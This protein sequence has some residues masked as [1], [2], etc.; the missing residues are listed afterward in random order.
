MRT[1]DLGPVYKQNWFVNGSLTLLGYVVT[2]TFLLRAQ[3]LHTYSLALLME[4]LLP[5]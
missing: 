4:L 1:T 5:L 2:Y 3:S